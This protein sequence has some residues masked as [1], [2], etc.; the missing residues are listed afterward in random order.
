MTF[1]PLDSQR[2]AGRS[3]Q[4]RCLPASASS[5]ETLTEI[6]NA[7]RV[8][9]LVPMQMT[10]EG[11]RRYVSRY[12]VDLQ[13]SVVVV[14]DGEP[15]GLGML[16][17]RGAQ[18]WITRLGIVPRWR[19]RAAGSLLAATLVEKA[20][21]RELERL[22]LEVI[23]DNHAARRLFARLGFQPSRQLAV[24]RREWA[25]PRDALRF[26]RE[27]VVPLGRR[28]T[29]ARLESREVGASWLTQTESFEKMVRL[30]GYETT[31]SSGARGWIAF[32]AGSS[33]L[34]HLVLG[35]RAVADERIG[36]T[37]LGRLHADH[38]ATRATVQNV[39]V[40]QSAW[41]IF[42]RAGYVEEFRRIE[43]CLALGR[44][45]EPENRPTADRP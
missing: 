41:S 9:Y 16:A 28:D 37:L 25:S 21:E 20:R 11:M 19:R 22:E 30:R 33:E 40:D 18:G 3:R 13:S 14:G 6:Y 26:A 44:D 39:P 29:L 32:R 38:P 2:P 17:I 27:P 31:G 35:G 4:M 23:R 10:V 36:L 7:A 43:L 5:L 34:D 15:A 1:D 8:D 12:D 42:R 45:L 24:G